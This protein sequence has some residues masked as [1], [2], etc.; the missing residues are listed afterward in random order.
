MCCACSRLIGICPHPPS[1]AAPGLLWSLFFSATIDWKD[2]SV[3]GMSQV[4]P[5]PLLLPYTR[6]QCPALLVRLFNPDPGPTDSTDDITDH[7][8]NDSH[9]TPS[10]ARALWRW[11]PCGL[12]RSPARLI[13][14]SFPP[15]APAHTSRGTKLPARLSTLTP[16]TASPRWPSQRGAPRRRRAS[17]LVGVPTLNVGMFSPCHN[18]TCSKPCPL[19][20]IAL[21]AISLRSQI[22]QQRL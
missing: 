16:D 15:K 7:K 9:F 11:S 1:S 14:H 2:R 22:Q 3:L 4:S 10:H 12:C 17:P 19:P 20:T 13:A 21:R 6:A 18:L 5:G 8:S